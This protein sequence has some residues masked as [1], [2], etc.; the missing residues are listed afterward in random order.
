MGEESKFLVSVVIPVFNEDKNIPILYEKLKNVVDNLPYHFEIIFV[1]DGSEDN[2]FDELKKI[3]SLDKRIKVIK[4]R[5]NFGKASAYSSGF[6]Y[7]RG[8]FVITL[9]G[10]LQDEP[11]EIPKFIDK[12]KE[13]YDVVNGWKYKGKGKF[14]KRV[15][16]KIFNRITSYLTG[17]KLHDFNCPF[18]GYRREVVENLRIYGDLYRFIPIIAVKR[19]FCVVEVKVENYPRKYGY[20]KYG[21]KRFVTG[22]LDLLTVLFLTKFAN[23]PLHLYGSV[24]IFLSFIGG[25]ILFHLFTLVLRG[26]G[27]GHRPLLILGVL[28]FILGIQFISVGLICEMIINT[29]DFT[30]DKL[31]IKEI[32]E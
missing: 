7:A 10:D 26:E 8:E 23:S 27:I 11:K 5:R 1:D 32:L 15:P 12:L 3:N 4:H 28:L 9:D 29:K 18:K 25:L 22:F 30:R 19:G 13:G 21:I 20:S 24:G 31:N 16:S 2:T 14:L 6:S 17:V